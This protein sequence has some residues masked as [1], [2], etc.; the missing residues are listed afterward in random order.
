LKST[1][2]KKEMH[3]VLF[4]IVFSYPWMLV[5]W[6]GD[7]CDVWRHLLPALTEFNLGVILFVGFLLDEFLARRKRMNEE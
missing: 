1:I 3:F 7:S 6:H 4:F 5:L 2:I